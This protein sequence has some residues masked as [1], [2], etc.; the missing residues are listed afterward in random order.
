MRASKPSLSR[1]KNNVYRVD[2][3]S[4]DVKVVVDDFVEPNGITFSPDE[5][6]L[7]IIDTGFTDNPDNPCISAC[8]T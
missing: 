2:P 1:R 6:K 7:Y 4:G 5:K 8:S 3:K